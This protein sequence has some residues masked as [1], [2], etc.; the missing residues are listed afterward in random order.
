MRKLS[1]KDLAVWAIAVVAF[2]P[3]L[4]V[5]NDSENLW[6]NL[7]GFAYIGLLVIVSRTSVG[8]MFFQRLERI[9]N[10]LFGKIGG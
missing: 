2:I 5:L 7:I 8:K 6:V 9:E 1:K 4:L 3:T 10:K